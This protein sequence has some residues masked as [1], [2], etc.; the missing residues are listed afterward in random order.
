MSDSAQAKQWLTLSEASK[1][2]GVHPA[3]LRAWADAG[4]APSFRT[5][6]GHRRF[7]TAD[8]HTFLL[9]ASSGPV[10]TEAFVDDSARFETALVQTRS[11]LRHLPPG[12]SGWYDAFDEAGRERQRNLGRQLFATALQ[13]L[14]RP[15]QQTELVQ[16][17]H[18]LGEAYAKSS[19]DYNISLLD[20]VR[21]FQY[22]RSNLHQAL[23]V[24]EDG[25]RTG[26]SGHSPALEVEDLRL[27]QDTDAFLNEVLFGLIGAYEQAILGADRPHD[28]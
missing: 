1:L 7:A 16:K 11:Q 20:S 22:F 23:A 25:P 14:T 3:T 10:E 13:Y 19:L 26:G 12:E 21:A 6:G 8:L 28:A 9:R 24:S 2:L 15:R 4:Q 27:R 5:P 17:A 18:R